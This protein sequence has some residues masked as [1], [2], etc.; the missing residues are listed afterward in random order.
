MTPTRSLPVV[1]IADDDPEDRSAV[2]R[3]LVRAGLKNLNV[4]ASDGDEAIDFLEDMA[5]HFPTNERSPCVLL[6][7]VK[8]PGGGGFEVLK[9]V[10]TQ[11]AFKRTKV[12]LMS[13]SD[14]PRLRQRAA[15]LGADAYFVKFPRGDELAKFVSAD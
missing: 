9:W 5:A 14:E 4:S 12:A 1:L 10:R 15:A 6:L 11:S 7:D 2:E 3:E 13:N 8:M